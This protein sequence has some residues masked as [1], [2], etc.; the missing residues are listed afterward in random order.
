MI[1]FYIEKVLTSQPKLW[2][3]ING[4]LKVSGYKISIQKPAVFLYTNN[5]ISG[6]IIL[7]TIILKIKYL[8]LNLMKKVKDLYI[9]N[10]VFNERNGREHKQMESYPIFKDW[11]N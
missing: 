1:Q 7:L 5:E 6:K 2:E 9:E 8:G 4:F 11:N 10:Y 3:P